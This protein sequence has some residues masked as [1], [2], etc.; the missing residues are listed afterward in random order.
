MNVTFFSDGNPACP[1]WSILAQLLV[2]TFFN[3]QGTH[4]A[5]GSMD[6]TAKLWDVGVAQ[7]KGHRGMVE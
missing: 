3:F 4:V 2:A 1:A 7:R 6:N 5:T